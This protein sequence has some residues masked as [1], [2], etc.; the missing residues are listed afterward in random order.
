M[1]QENNRIYNRPEPVYHNNSSNQVEMYY[2]NSYHY[3]CN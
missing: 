1:S 3:W 2:N